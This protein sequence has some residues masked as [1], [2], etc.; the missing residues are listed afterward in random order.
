[1]FGGLTAWLRSLCQWQPLPS[2]S[3]LRFGAVLIIVAMVPAGGALQAAGLDL[4]QAQQHLEAM[5]Y[6]PGPADGVIGPRTSNALKAFQLDSGVAVSGLLDQATREALGARIEALERKL[7]VLLDKDDGPPSIPMLRLDTGMHTAPI[8]GIASDRDGR[9]LVTASDD[10]TLRLWSLDDGVLL[11]TLRVPIGIGNAGRL[12]AVAMDPDGDWIAAGG[13]TRY[14]NGAGHGV[15]LFDRATGQVRQRLGDLPDMIT[16]L[17]VSSDGAFLAAG[18]HGSAGLRVWSTN[19]WQPVAEDA[20]YSGGIHRCG[21][22]PEGRLVVSSDDSQLRLYGKDFDRGAKVRAP[23]GDEPFAAVFSPDGATIAVGYSDSTTL[24]LLSSVDLSHRYSP[25]TAGIDNGNLA[26]VAWSK[27][28]RRLYAGGRFEG[29]NHVNP[30][31]VWDDAGHGDRQFWGGTE[32]TITDLDALPGGRLIVAMAN[33]AWLVVDRHGDGLFGRQAGIADLRGKRGESFTLSDDGSRVRF[34]LGYGDL[35]PVLFDL[36]TRDLVSAPE[37]DRDLSAPLIAAPGIEIKGWKSSATPSLNGKS[38]ALLPHERCRSAALSPDHEGLVLG[39]DWSLR[40]FDASGNEVWSIPVPGT[41]W[42]VNISGDGR[43]VVAALAD[44]TVRWYRYR[45][46]EELLALFTHADDQRWVAWTPSGYYS[47][48][49]GADDLIGW[50]LNNDMDRA[51]DFYPVG[52]LRDHFYRPEVVEAVLEKGDEALAL[53]SA[54]EK[55]AKPVAEALPPLVEL[56]SPMDGDAFDDAEVGL[57]FR[58]RSH[59]GE[60]I[61]DLRVMVDGGL[62]EIEET[63][64]V[65]KEGEGVLTVTLPTRDLELG[66]VAENRHG[67]GQPASVR[68]VWTGRPENDPP[69]KPKLYVLSVGVSDYSDPAMRLDY[70]AKDARDF[71]RVLEQQSGGLY[72]DVET[73]VLED[74]DADE[75]GLLQGFEW[76]RRQVTAQ[77][78]TAV[79]LAGHGVNDREGNYWFLPRAADTKHLGRT[80][81]AY[82]SIKDAIAKLP[83]RTIAFLDTGHHAEHLGG[84]VRGGVADINALVNDLAA[85]ENGVIV[86]ASSSGRQ[87]SVE[88]D[89]WDNGA[90]TTALLEALS[91]KLTGAG[92]HTITIEQL[93]RYLIE[94][95][96]DLTSNQQTPVADR[97]AMVPDFPFA[98]TTQKGTVNGERAVYGLP[99][100]EQ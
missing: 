28:G 56:F 61:T 50:H 18:L 6:E 70:A 22:G 78:V 33:P 21:F 37:L 80:A 96:K 43:L 49:P 88:D 94:R 95:V 55:E 45:D 44:G 85:P 51:A 9:W 11:R 69:P 34:G 30:I 76:L 39:A 4:K 67:A 48:S 14:R 40:R 89:Q 92:E 68:L 57:R 58:L 1:M 29:R 23:G 8:K 79:F 5:G 90:F 31:V 2:M 97:P 27:D 60:P 81:V 64:K 32:N 59:G 42:G 16:A 26:R 65:S 17:C 12:F 100:S 10:K 62:L 7:A 74:E 63:P 38:L 35:R 19:D 15:Y 66:L 46:G 91:G 20:D 84:D 3:L 98:V 54:G 24:D 71:A 52:L 82:R 53:E 36:P 72:R 41:A 77:D 83:G 13:W 86:F 73:R 75:N 87:S 25:D 47:A 93:G 99:S